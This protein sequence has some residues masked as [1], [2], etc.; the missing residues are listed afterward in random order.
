MEALGLDIKLLVAQI[1]NF[2]ILFF[3]LKKVLYKPIIKILDDRKKAIDESLKSS[4]KIEEEL[5][6]LEEKKTSVIEKTQSQANKDKENLII[7]AQEEKRK[8]IDEAKKTAETEVAKSVKKIEAAQVA[9]YE[10]I[11]KRFLNDTVTEIIK[12]INSSKT[13]GKFTDNILK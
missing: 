4:K 1:I 13:K 5:S 3:V 7:L 12:K 8:I 11:K 10:D 2:G 9:S 6:K